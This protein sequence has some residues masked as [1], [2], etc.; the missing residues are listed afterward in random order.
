MR[1][2]PTAM[3]VNSSGDGGPATM[4]PIDLFQDSNQHVLT[5]EPETR[6]LAL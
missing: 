2:H 1:F 4:P 6:N 5:A 3:T